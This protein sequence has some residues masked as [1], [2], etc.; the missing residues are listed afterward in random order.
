MQ[1]HIHV[2]D[3]D[4]LWAWLLGTLGLSCDV[5][6]ASCGRFPTLT[7]CG[8]RAAK[9]GPTHARCI[10]VVSILAKRLADWAASTGAGRLGQF[11]TRA[12][13]LT[14]LVRDGAEE[15]TT[16]LCHVMPH[17]HL[18]DDEAWLDLHAEHQMDLVH[19][20]QSN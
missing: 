2:Q 16:H 20:K 7:R 5:V 13:L 18:N 9:V 12:G 3:Y 14:I 11:V 19:K 10:S 8:N 17:G 6:C 15:C 4:G 1:I